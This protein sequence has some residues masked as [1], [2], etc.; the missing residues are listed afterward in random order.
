MKKSLRISIPQPCH[1]DWNKMTPTEK[2]RFCASCTKEVFDFSSSTDEELVKLAYSGG[3]LCGRFRADQLEREI[4]L[5]RKSGWSLAPLAASVLLP[6]SLMANPK[7]EPR[8]VESTY[9]SLGVGSLNKS[10]VTLTGQ[11]KDV[12]GLPIPGAKILNVDTGAIVTTKHKL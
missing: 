7:P 9:M 4:K 11:I 2:G 12:E 5:E 3:N 1:E 6:L 10:R 8:P